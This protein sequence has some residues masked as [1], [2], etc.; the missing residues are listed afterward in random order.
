MIDDMDLGG[1]LIK[2][3]AR[4][5]EVLDKIVF[6]Q[7]QNG[8]ENCEMESE[9]MQGSAEEHAADLMAYSPDFEDDKWLLDHNKTALI[10][11]CQRWLDAKRRAT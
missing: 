11:S 1:M 6:D 8:L 4:R 7:L 10:A 5:N 2:E 9:Y 3:A